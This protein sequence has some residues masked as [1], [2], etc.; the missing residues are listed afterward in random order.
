MDQAQRR[1]G[2]ITKYGARRLHDF[3][4]TGM[5]AVTQGRKRISQAGCLYDVCGRRIQIIFAQQIGNI[6]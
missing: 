5:M 3:I 2:V 1:I 4:Q 6:T